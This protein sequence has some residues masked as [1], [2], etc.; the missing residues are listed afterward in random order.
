MSRTKK[1]IFNAILLCSLF[2]IMTPASVYGDVINAATQI[3]ITAEEISSQNIESYFNSVQE[4]YNIGNPLT[5]IEALIKIDNL[6]T[7]EPGNKDLKS[8][9]NL[10]LGNFYSM[11]EQFENALTAFN[12]VS[13][14][15]INQKMLI[16]KQKAWFYN[17]LKKFNEAK[18]ELKILQNL[19]AKEYSSNP[20]VMFNY[21]VDYSYFLLDSCQFNEFMQ[22]ENKLKK[23]ISQ[24]P[25][26]EEQ[27]RAEIDLNQLLVTY[28][29]CR[30]MQDKA[31]EI[32]DKNIKLAEANGINYK[33]NT[34]H[35]YK[36]Y[37][38]S[39]KDLKSVKEI[40]DKQAAKA[41][42]EY[43]KNSY[44]MSYV[45][46]DYINYYNNFY[47]SNT[48][49]KYL[50]KMLKVLEPY[51][52]I[53]PVKYGNAMKQTAVIKMSKGDNEA[54]LKF[55]NEAERYYAKAA[56]LNSYLYYDTN[57]IKGSIYKNTGNDDKALECYKKAESIINNL[58]K[59]Y[60]T[61]ETYDIEVDIAY[62]YAKKN[63]FNNAIKKIESAIKTIEKIYNKNNVQVQM[64]N[65]NK[66]NML[67][68]FN[69][70]KEA[71]EVLNKISV[72]I[73]NNQLEGY[74]Y[75]FLYQYYVIMINKSLRENNTDKAKIYLQKVEKYA[76]SK[77]QKKEIKNLKK[78]LI[79][80]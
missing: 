58:Q 65:L 66:Y 19:I 71:E 18:Q 43:S 47:K 2:C 50:A 45:Y 15:D 67:N 30:N 34:T 29:I 76:T 68:Q 56:S 32:L 28:Y 59:N 70:T 55:I 60:I 21:Y 49:E 48:N 53:I 42:K 36:D 73:D 72:V 54:A 20:Q 7:S 5:S 10:E 35:F 57:K 24:I 26:G 51:K 80:Q 39:I 52:N 33:D 3:S 41:K 9:Y 37:Y 62:L 8:R 16:A 69:K 75:D 74:N 46:G 13:T 17:S 38:Y 77:R 44:Y 63:D 27:I 4:G 11:F 12:N 6:T 78:E 23:L 22:N 64:L 61:R 79:K 1:S 25:A 14:N 40:I 31:V